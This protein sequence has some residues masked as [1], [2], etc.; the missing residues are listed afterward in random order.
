MTAAN[1]TTSAPI[2]RLAFPDRRV[3]E[4]TY[5]HVFHGL[6]KKKMDLT[7]NPWGMDFQIGH[8]AG[9]S[10]T[11]AS[12]IA[13][14]LP[15]NYKGLAFSPAN[16]Y[17]T[18]DIETKIF[19]LAKSPDGLIDD[20]KRQV[21]GV[22]IAAGN[23]LAAA[24][25]GDGGGSLAT[26][27]SGSGTPTLTLANPDDIV[28]FEV[29]MHL[30]GST[31]SGAA[32]GG[33]AITGGV[34]AVISAMD[35]DVGTITTTGG[36]NWSAATGINGIADGNFLF[37][38][39]DYALALKGL[40]AWLPAAAVGNTDSFGGLNRFTDTRLTGSRTAAQATI[41]AT[42][43]KA[44]ARIYRDGGK[45]DTI[46]LNTE[47]FDRLNRELGAAV[48]YVDAMA[49]GKVGAGY[50]AIEIVGQGGT[51]KVYSDAYCPKSTAF[52][53]QI[54]TWELWSAGQPIGNLNDGDKLPMS[55]NANSDAFEIRY[56]GYV[57]LMCSAPWKNGRAALP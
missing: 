44:M 40:G 36:V 6:L 31:T 14:K 41:L 57:Q 23:A 11:F 55:R 32:T 28:R 34:G 26:I 39:G 43:Q 5:E 19:R 16:Y 25:Y 10:S 1:L 46:L 12:A 37:R 17:Q 8:A 21:E 4:I 20:V 53:L 54:D 51:A 13:N 42:L 3:L 24:E 15:N 7:G 45:T 35:S 48:R 47:D 2:F 38:Q 49:Y 30:D 18:S 52:L 29:G 50:K 9:G 22:I 33:A 27:G 56:G